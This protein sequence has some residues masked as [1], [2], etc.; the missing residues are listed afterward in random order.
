M[1]AIYVLVSTHAAKVSTMK[2]SKDNVPS[3]RKPRRPESNLLLR[4]NL[5]GFYIHTLK[6]KMPTNFVCP[7]CAVVFIRKGMFDNHCCVYPCKFCIKTFPRKYNL[8]VHEK[9]CK[10]KLA[11]GMG[12]IKHILLEVQ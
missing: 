2:Q 5:K 9:T 6:G 8:E 11:M 3:K 1:I 4:S 7:K 10:V 12:D